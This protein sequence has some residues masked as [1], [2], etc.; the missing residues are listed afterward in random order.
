MDKVTKAQAEK[1]LAT[2]KAKWPES[3]G[4]SHL[5]GPT[6]YPAEHE[7]MEYGR[8]SIAWEGAPEDWCFIASMEIK[9]PGVHL[10][11]MT[12]WCLGLYPA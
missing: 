6:L 4:Y 2:L 10:E 8:W 5:D 11:S 7:G 9:V 12:S 3:N 1:V